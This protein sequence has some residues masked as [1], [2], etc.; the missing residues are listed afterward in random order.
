MSGVQ[1]AGPNK[2]VISIDNAETYKGMIV[3]WFAEAT[4]KLML[5][6]PLKN[7]G[8][9]QLP[10]I[11]QSLSR[12]VKRNVN[13][14]DFILLTSND[15][16]KKHMFYLNTSIQI[17][18]NIQQAQANVALPPA[19]SLEYL[20]HIRKFL[21]EVKGRFQKRHTIYVENALLALAVHGAYHTHYYKEFKDNT[22]RYY[23]VLADTLQLGKINLRN[24][25][26]EVK[27]ISQTLRKADASPVTL[28]VGIA[29]LY[30]NKIS[31]FREGSATL[32]HVIISGTRKKK[33]TVDRP[34]LLSFEQRDLT[35][36][37]R[38]IESLGWNKAIVNLVKGYPILNP[39][40]PEDVKRC[41]RAVKSFIESLT[42]AI[43]VW[44]STGDEQEIYRVLRTL[45]SEDF[46]AK[47]RE[48]FGN[49]WNTIK[50]Q[51]IN[52][53]I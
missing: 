43:Y 40:D 11:A 30:A 23:Y 7:I 29:S 24:L 33:K 17:L 20:E 44:H 4:T 2:L 39:K 26:K 6:S 21:P 19:F 16:R 1:S 22:V 45:T 25:N 15:L 36:L 32:T 49:K 28:Y 50:G 42:R 53:K 34:V 5:N 27:D 48:Y 8:Q 13:P 38:D 37:A 46:D 18:L 52:I 12:F 14:S 47:A 9:Q 31:S 3:V 10:Q 35:Y 51:L 41:K